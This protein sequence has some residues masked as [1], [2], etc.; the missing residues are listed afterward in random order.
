MKELA[1]GKLLVAARGLPDPNFSDTVVLLAELT[2]EG[3]MG[4]IVNRT[5]DVPI[6]RF[7][8]EM[9]EGTN[10]QT[11][12]VGGPVQPRGAVALLR[13]SKAERD[14]RHVF[15]DVYLVNTRET[16]EALIR[17]GT[18]PGRFRVYLGYA[19]WGAGQLQDETARGSWHVLDGDAAIVFD[20]DPDTLWQRLIRRTGGLSVQLQR[21]GASSIF[22]SGR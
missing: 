10:P 17:I 22:D 14:S 16:L 13:S 1:V 4:V 7:V 19:G 5:T 20:R 12:F 18:G 3:A 15:A 8:P 2:D 11:A 9:A 21:P 6:E